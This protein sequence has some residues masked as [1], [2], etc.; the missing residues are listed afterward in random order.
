VISISKYV[1][2][3]LRRHYKFD[4]SRIREIFNGVDPDLTS[5]EE[6]AR[7]REEVRRQFHLR[8][9]DLMVLCVAHNFKLKGVDKLVEALSIVYR[10]QSG[11]KHA[12][13]HVGHCKVV[14]VGRDNPRRA[15]QL[16]RRLGVADHVLFAGPTQ[17]ILAFFHAADV[18]AHPTFYDPCSRVVLEAMAAGL[19]V[20]TTRFNG[21]AERVTEGRE[22]FV[23]ESPMDVEALADR[24]IRLM[25]NDCRRLCAA[26]APSAVSEV[27]MKAH[28]EKVCSLYRELLTGGYLQREG[29]R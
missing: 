24:M 13:H 9:D 16:A 3:Q 21:A 7:Q 8:D 27:T 25:D 22:G 6:R 18:L 4:P 5:A 10:R 17:R 14:I 2:D 23:I 26:A 15:V 29:Y 19:P 20:I 1:T 12:K 11:H 28:A